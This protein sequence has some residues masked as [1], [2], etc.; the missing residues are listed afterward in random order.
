[1]QYMSNMREERMAPIKV[2]IP[3]HILSYLLFLLNKMYVEVVVNK[4]L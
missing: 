3:Q 4:A 1:M 2:R